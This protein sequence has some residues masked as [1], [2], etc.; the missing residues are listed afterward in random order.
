[1]QVKGLP[2]PFYQAIRLRVVDGSPQAQERLRW[3]NAW[4][5]LQRQGLSSTEA[6]HILG[7]ARATLYRWQQR[8][9]QQGVRG[10][11]VRSRRP[12]RVRQASW[13]PGLVVAVR[14]WREQYPRWGKETLVLLLARQGW[15]TSASTVGRILVHL[16]RT[17]QFL[18]PPR[19][20]VSA[21][22]RR[23]LRPYGVRKPREYVP[24]QPGDL[25]Q[26]D[27]VDLRPLPGVLL[28]QFTAID[29]VSRWGVAAVRTRATATTATDFLTIL[30]ARLAA[31]LHAVQVDGGSEFMADFE[32][33][34]Q[35]R[36]IRLF[37][38]PPR[39]PKL[40]GHVERLNRTATEEFWECYDG[41]LDLATVQPALLAWEHTY[42]TI[43][44]HRALQG[45]TPL[46]YLTE[47]HPD[48]IPK[49]SHMY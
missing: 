31:P 17:G 27:T 45:R 10:L 1:M 33:A 23:L 21:S 30:Q 19:R 15:A 29:V 20:A 18:A 43:R 22:R 9:R 8:F 5:A 36:G 26:V 7:L 40:N 49:L 32:Q 24:T 39:S 34:C 44:P 47:R 42:N 3:L 35:Q 38:L 12:H 16:R 48:L 25:V 6:S 46:E 2:R 14:Q 4:E 41:D 13:D 28:K 11:E 37:V